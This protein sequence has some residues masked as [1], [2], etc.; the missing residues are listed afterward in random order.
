[1]GRC[2]GFYCLARLAELTEG[3]FPESLNI[4]AS[5]G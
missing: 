2:Q 5:N 4:G 1:M 3:R